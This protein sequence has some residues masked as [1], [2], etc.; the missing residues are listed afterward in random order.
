VPKL[1][2][3]LAALAAPALP[4]MLSTSGAA[5]TW[6]WRYS[7]DGKAEQRDWSSEP[8][9]PGQ[10]LASGTLTTS[11]QADSNGFYKI[12]AISGQRNGVAIAGLMPTCTSPPP[13]DRENKYPTDSLIRTTLS[14]EP[15]L[16]R[17]GFGYRLQS[18]EFVTV[19]SSNWWRPPGILEFFSNLPVIHEGPVE[20]RAT[21]RAPAAGEGPG[22]RSH[23]IAQFDLAGL[24][25]EK[26]IEILECA[27]LRGIVR[28]HC[29]RTAWLAASKRERSSLQLPKFKTPVAESTARSQFGLS[30]ANGR[31][32]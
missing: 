7:Y 29:R 28:S 12:L 8:L 18:G 27:A 4:V 17:F 1:S 11:D 9:F 6:D 3:P 22:S 5:L 16:A 26:R 13:Y 2:R 15:Q 20:F 19:F 10:I 30:A 14:G 24:R 21:I 31:W 32:F 25:R 23:S